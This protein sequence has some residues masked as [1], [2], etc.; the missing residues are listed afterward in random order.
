MTMKQK[1]E[2]VMKKKIISI[3][4]AVIIMI[5][6]STGALAVGTTF[7]DVPESA[8]YYNYVTELA[9][10][11]VISGYEDG[12]FRP[13]GTVTYGEALKLVL[14]ATGRGNQPSVGGH[15]ASGYL[16]YALENGYI[17]DVE[18]D[19]LN[20]PISRLEVAHLVANA[21]GITEVK[22]TESPFA[23]TDDALAIALYDAKILNG[24]NIDGVLCLN[25]SAHIIRAEISTIIYRMMDID[26]AVPD[27]PTG[28]VTEFGD[29]YR[30]V[31]TCSGGLNLRSEPSTE[32][33]VIKVIPTGGSA[34]AISEANGWYKVKYG[35]DIGYVSA[36]YCRLIDTSNS[37]YA[38]IRGELLD[39]AQQFIGCPYVYGGSGPDVFDCSGFTMYVFAQ[40]GYELYHSAR[41]QFASGMEITK[42]ELLPGDLVFF[43]N[44]ETTWI[45]HV[46]IYMGNGEFIHASSSKGVIISSM[47]SDWY[48]SHYVCSARIIP[49]A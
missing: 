49:E 27:V 39:Y 36:D 1:T 24:T 2:I 29:N 5:T 20:N 25:G 40:Y 12:T 34:K 31:V 38:G 3:I 48:S 17:S 23:D 13:D 42:E 45:G 7:S 35:V 32:S 46:G 19:E 8:W 26:S 33:A 9:N 4:L 16:V 30:V 14:S 21:S 47:Y 43:S 18:I 41:S 6:C 10:A 28:T 11:K 44:Y 22:S 37:D 15:W